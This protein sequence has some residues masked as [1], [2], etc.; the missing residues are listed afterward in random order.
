MTRAIHAVLVPA[1][2][3]AGAVLLAVPP[4]AQGQTTPLERADIL[5]ELNE[6]DGDLGFHALIAGEAAK[7]LTVRGPDGL[8]ILSVRPVG[9][10]GEQGLT[11]LSFES[12]EPESEAI[13]PEEFFARFPE[14]R[15][16]IA[17]P[18]TEGGRVEGS[19]KFSHR[20]PAPPDNVA[21]SGIPLA[22][23]CEAQDPPA[24]GQP[25]VISWDPVTTS[26]PTIGSP[27]DAPIRIQRYQLVVEREEPTALV[28]SVDLP[29]DL[30]A[31]EITLPA[32]FVALG[33]EFKY[34]IVVR[35]KNGNQTALESCFALE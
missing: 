3:A 7:R 29:G 2:A 14:G 8:P 33:A 22:E 24:V 9:S 25:I 23:D 18:A 10:L 17:G 16:T 32:E 4:P 35:A 15:Y 28:H 11:E 26:H 6:T 31:Y 27:N 1:A 12:T 30:R 20:M 34:G 19:A 5:A 13:P 21:V